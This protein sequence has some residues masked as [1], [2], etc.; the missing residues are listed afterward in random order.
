MNA[1]VAARKIKKLSGKIGDTLDFA[2]TSSS[3]SA[4]KDR[5]LSTS[6]E[7]TQLVDWLAANQKRNFVPV[8]KALKVVFNSFSGI[9]E[10]LESGELNKRE[11]RA[12]LS[13]ARNRFHPNLEQALSEEVERLNEREESKINLSEKQ[14][15]VKQKLSISN[16]DWKSALKIVRDAVNEIDAKKAEQQKGKDQENLTS[17]EQLTNQIKDLAKH[18]KAL[19]VNL[20]GAYQ[21]VRLPI[22]SIFESPR[23]NAQS[24]WQKLGIRVLSIED[25]PVLQDQLLILVSKKS[26][27]KYG[28]SPKEFAESAIELLNEKGSVNYALVSDRSQASPR[29]ADHIMFWMLPASKVSAIVK[30]AGFGSAKVSWG[31][32]FS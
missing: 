9:S 29:N 5:L 18:R 32:P 1:E 24:F 8:R 21:V 11:M 13:N 17:D 14:E 26:A 10:G 19:P 2:E 30:A 28:S 20:A 4:C 12:M 31:L 15:E 16:T 7:I 27:E 6:S 22:V 3:R 25:Y 23:L